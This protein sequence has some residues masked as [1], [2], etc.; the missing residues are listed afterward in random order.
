MD[1]MIKNI[2]EQYLISPKQ[3]RQ[4]STKRVN[5]K[6]KEISDR[7]RALALEKGPGSRLPTVREL[8]E[9]LNTSSAT[10]TAALD[11]L[12]AEQ[13][14]SRKE[15]QG[16]FVADTIHQRSIHIVFNMFPLA[17]VGSSPF[18]SLLWGHLAQEVEQRTSIKNE[19]YA[20][21]FL[22]RPMPHQ[23]PDSH[24]ALL[25]SPTVDGCVIIGFNAHSFDH[26]SLLQVPHVVYAGGG[27]WMA[28]TDWRTSGRLAAEAL[29]RQGCQ[30]IGYWAA[31]EWAVPL[32][33]EQEIFHFQQALQHARHPIYP[34]L[35]RSA[36]TPP[37]T[38]R[39]TLTNQERGY[40]LVK[41]TFGPS[42]STR[43]DGIYISDD[44]VTDGALVAFDELGIQVGRD[45]KIVSLA[46]ADSP[47]LFGRTREMTLIEVDAADIVRGMFTL[48]DTFERGEKPHGDTVFIQ[49]RL[50]T[51]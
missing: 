28:K 17:N 12:E 9:L 50:R 41:E 23:L 31:D 27:D 29:M 8:C 3:R 1:D 15:R 11:L 43:P 22:W 10:V 36:P 38:G 40:L 45:V 34:E 18:W 35:F 14:L 46:I 6:I 4:A 5:A 49:P 16:V 37:A 13:L 39:R 19:H 24:I 48:L 7:I 25:N 30:R 32:H 44:L 51:H 42:G 26:R 21:H 47:I 20:F 33:E 2:E